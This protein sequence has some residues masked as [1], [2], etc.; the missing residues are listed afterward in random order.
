MPTNWNDTSEYFSLRTV[1]EGGDIDKNSDHFPNDMIPFG[2][3]HWRMG[4][5]SISFWF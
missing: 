1:S 5:G 3:G 2:K 4:K